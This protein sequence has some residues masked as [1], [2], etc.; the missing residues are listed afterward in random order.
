MNSLK[1]HIFVRCMHDYFL[2]IWSPASA[3]PSVLCKGALLPV[4]NSV[5]RQSCHYHNSVESKTA[6]C[7]A[8]KK[9]EPCNQWTEKCLSTLPFWSEEGIPV[10]SLICWS[11]LCL[12]LMP[13]LY[14]SSAIATNSKMSTVTLL[15]DP[16]YGSITS[17]IIYFSS[18]TSFY[19]QSCQ[20]I[21][22]ASKRAVSVSAHTHIF[23][24]YCPG[25]LFYVQCIWAS[26]SGNS[27]SF[28]Y[29]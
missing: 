1:G 3:A 28:I 25:F 27:W 6:L 7:F 24:P 14:S 15:Q 20:C 18:L 23:K 5:L 4:Y 13:F 8:H 17:M 10:G 26:S 12:F 9:Q 21:L 22:A 2:L 19:H 11:T 29:S 16:K